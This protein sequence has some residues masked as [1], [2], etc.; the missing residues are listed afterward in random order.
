MVICTQIGGIVGRYI[1]DFTWLMFLPSCILLLLAHERLHPRFQRY[2]R[3]FVLVSF[4]V[5]VTFCLFNP[6]GNWQTSWNASEPNPYYQI[7]N[8]IQFWL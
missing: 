3:L 5:G 8:A 6:M 7:Q 4:F 1:A 2:V